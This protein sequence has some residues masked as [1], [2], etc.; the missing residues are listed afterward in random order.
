MAQVLL[1]SVAEKTGF[2]ID[3]LELDMQLDVDLGIDSIKRVEILSA[4]QDRLPDM[5]SGPSNSA[6][7]N[8]SQIAIPVRLTSPLPR[9]DR[10]SFCRAARYR[11]EW[12]TGPEVTKRRPGPSTRCA[13]GT[14]VSPD[15]PAT[16]IRLARSSRRRVACGRA[17]RCGSPTM[18][19]RWRKR[20]ERRLIERGYA[21]KVIAPR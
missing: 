19:H 14:P 2:P 13:G 8:A 3:M 11:D 21:A 18:A 12:V 20:V 6:R 15:A 9:S 10:R 16:R 7:S 17:G 5:R 1:E 4:V